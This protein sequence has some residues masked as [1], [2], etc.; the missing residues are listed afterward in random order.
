[1]NPLAKHYDNVSQKMDNRAAQV[2]KKETIQK[3]KIA[4]PAVMRKL[5]MAE[6]GVAE[7]GSP[8]QQAAIAIAMKKA[9][10]KPKGVSEAPKSA[11]V[12][13]GNAIKRVQGTTAAS[14]A[15]SVIP[16]SIPKPEPKKDEKTVP[17]SENVENIIDA[18]INKIIVNEAIQNNRR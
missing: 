14:Q 18:L 7:A 17:V 15:R 13:L 6:Q 10:K 11:A 2:R 9:G 16:S 1:M 4:S 12:R 8:A 3:N 5:G